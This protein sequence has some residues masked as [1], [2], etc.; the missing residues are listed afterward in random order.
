MD[1]PQRR[2]ELDSLVD[3]VLTAPK[4]EHVCEALIRQVGGRELVKRRRFKDAV[5]ATKK[6][7]HQIGGAYSLSEIDYIQSLHELRRTVESGDREQLL[8]ICERLMGFHAST[9]ERVHILGEF[10]ETTLHSIQPVRVILDVACGLNPLAL[11]WM[12]LSEGVEYYAYD[13]YT[14]LVGFVQEF[15]GI[16]GVQGHAEARDVTQALPEQ[17]ADL[18]LVLKTIPCLDQL[19]KT[20][21]IRLL[22]TLDADHILMSFP[23]QSLGGRSK[24]MVKHYEARFH[25][26]IRGKP[27]AVQR[28]EFDTE[29]AFLVT[30]R[31]SPNAPLARSAA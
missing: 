23:V 6:K 24:G 4:Y 20:A 14:D 27:W 29:L 10:Y 30:K 16:I 22:E 12:P 21:G 11:P 17:G 8:D 3:A 26:L 28:F 1:T 15:L 5:K 18:A 25:E 7:L 19:D 2:G 9:R 31:E 13:V